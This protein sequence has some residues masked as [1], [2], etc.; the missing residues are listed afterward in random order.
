MKI[1]RE[2]EKEAEREWGRRTWYVEW[3]LWLAAVQ[4]RCL[5]RPIFVWPR[6]RRGQ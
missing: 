2:A 4:L 6:A 5:F 3:R 1:E